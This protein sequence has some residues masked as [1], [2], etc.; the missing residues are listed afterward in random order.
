MWKR[1]NRAIRA[2]MSPEPGGVVSRQENAE[3]Q[4]ET[5]VYA[6]VFGKIRLC[7][8]TGRQGEMLLCRYDEKT[9][10]GGRSGTTLVRAV[11]IVPRAEAIRLLAEEKAANESKPGNQKGNSAW[12]GTR[13]SGF[14]SPM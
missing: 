7:H 9:T 3:N 11:D 8:V 4:A 5:H 10:Q 13:K 14:T 12:R 1:L 6:R 2:F